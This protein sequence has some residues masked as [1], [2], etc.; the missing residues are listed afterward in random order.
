MDSLCVKLFNDPCA[1]DPVK[2]GHDKSVQAFFQDVLSVLGEEEEEKVYGGLAK[3][4]TR[5]SVYEEVVLAPVLEGDSSHYMHQ[6]LI[7][8]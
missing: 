8:H 2:S 4:E 5:L 3:P 7:H 6:Q 1:P